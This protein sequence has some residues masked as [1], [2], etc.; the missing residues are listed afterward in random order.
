MTYN[1]YPA[2]LFAKGRL[3]RIGVAALLLS[4]AGSFARPSGAVEWWCHVRIFLPLA[5]RLR[6]MAA[7]RMGSWWGCSDA[8]W[9]TKPARNPP[10]P[11]TCHPGA[12]GLVHDVARQTAAGCARNSRPESE[13]HIC[14][15]CLT[16]APSA[17]PL[18]VRSPLDTPASRPSRQSPASRRE[19]ERGP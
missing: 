4:A 6:G 7:L 5:P 1:K 11:A 3:T 13:G 15:V 8:G 19:S 9:R 17:L 10:T 18:L 16:G 2:S 12:S 14:C